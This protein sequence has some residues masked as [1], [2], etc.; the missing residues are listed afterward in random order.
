MDWVFPDSEEGI[1]TA[2]A[3]GGLI[4]W[5]NTDLFPAHPLAKILKSP[6]DLPE[7]FPKYIGQDLKYFNNFGKRVFSNGQDGT[8]HHEFCEGFVL[9]SVSDIPKDL[10]YPRI[11]KS[12]FGRASHEIIN[13]VFK[14]DNAEQMLEKAQYLL[15]GHP[16]IVCEEYLA[17][18]EVTV[19]VLPAGIWDEPI[20]EARGPKYFRP[21]IRTGHVNGILPHSGDGPLSGTT[22]VLTKDEMSGNKG[23]IYRWL[24]W[25]VA[26]AC[27]GDNARAPIQFNCRRVG[28]SPMDQFKIFEIVELP[29][30]YHLLFLPSV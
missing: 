18:E 29:V 4:L 30:S 24:N 9:E 28:F 17:G 19:C 3:K 16:R 5:M 27:S 20:G 15:L 21:V 6:G 11:L 14:V 22:R 13:G 23:Q 7:G 2:I 8:S 1:R 25:T 10:K 26:G 12:V